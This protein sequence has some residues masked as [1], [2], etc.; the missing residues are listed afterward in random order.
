MPV[1]NAVEQDRLAKIAATVTPEDPVAIMYTSGTTGR[2][3]GVVLD[4]LGLIN[5][6]MVC[7][8]TSG[9]FGRRQ[10]LSVFPAFSHV[11]QYLHCTGGTSEGR[12]PDHALQEI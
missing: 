11:R 4:H 12:S 8:Q 5:K 3:K 7:H 2:P 6:S 9:D 10:T 1:S